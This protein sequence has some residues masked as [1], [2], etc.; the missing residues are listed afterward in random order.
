M[1]FYLLVIFLIL[2]FLASATHNRGGE[3]SYV[4]LTGNTYRFTI[5]TCTK[6]SAIADRPELE[7]TWGD[8]TGK[9]TVLRSSTVSMAPADAQKNY[10]II[11]HTFAG[12]GTFRVTMEDPNRNAGVIN[13][14]GATNS[15]QFPFCIATEIVISPFLGVNNS[16][17]FDDCPCPEL[18]CVNKR[19]CYNPQATDPDGDSLSYSLV[20]CLGLNCLAMSTPAVYQ[21]PS[22][23]GGTISID[24]LTG[25]M[26]W[27]N[28][29]RLGEYNIAVLVTEWRNG[30]KIGSVLRD[31]Q[32]TVTVCNNDPPLIRSIMDT[33]VVAG[34]SISIPVSA[35]DPNFGDRITLTATGAPLTG[36]SNPGS[37]T[38]VSGTSP[39]SSNF[40]WTTD[41]SNVRKAPFSLYFVAT[42][43]GLQ[44]NLSDYR[45]V[46]ITVKAPPPTGVVAT[47]LSGNVVVS[48]DQSNCSN[49]KGY[50]VYRKKGSSNSS[51]DCCG[52]NSPIDMGYTFIGQTNS[53]SDTS[54]VDIANLSVGEEYCYVVT[55]VYPIDYESCISD[56]ACVTLKRDVPIITHVT[57]LNTDLSSGVDSIIWA[58]ATDID[59][60]TDYPPPYLYKIFHQS[61]FTGA[62][63]LIYTSP[64]YPNLSVS[65]TVFVHSG[66]NSQTSP[67][68]Y[69][70][71]MYHFVGSD[72]LLIGQSN[73]ASSV[74]LTTIPNDNQIALNWTENVPWTNNSY[75]IYRGNSI[76]GTFVLIGATTAQSFVDSNLQN[77]KTY[78]YK[79]KS[80][81][82][83]TDPSIV[84]PLENF[85]QE[86]CDSPLDLT[87]PC[88]PVLAIDNS[89]E[90]ELNYLSWTNPNNTC[91]DDVT[92]YRVFYSPTSEGPFTEISV[93]NDPND[94][95]LTHD[96]MG[97]IAGCYYVTALDSVQY[98]NES[99]PSNV[100]CVD[101]CPIYFLPNVFTPNGDGI[102]DVFIPIL[103]YKFID[104]IEFVIYNRWGNEVFRTSDPMINWTGIDLET[105]KEVVDGVYFYACRVYSIRLSGLSETKLKGSISVYRNGSGR[106]N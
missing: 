49:A 26:C 87:P 103:P 25:T 28:P 37:F 64:F 9:D 106:A 90:D 67:N 11:D 55:I 27:L 5:T 22:S 101:N 89:C 59:T 38:S 95:T 36:V 91:A 98:N 84:S 48:W 68:N 41:C 16:V 7:I 85:S 50:K 57:V 74:F 43:N 31:I 61:G 56:E 1:R 40:S 47:P 81:G 29:A 13:I 60:V 99:E 105:G 73:S 97:S 2:G 15:D 63:N 42:D 65:D 86:V 93:I 83:Y 44:V 71:R 6:S 88:P 30:V 78:C 35:T 10:Y 39:I 66:I 3:I 54:F 24:P 104:S 4:H 96:D 17:V 20:P 52:Q 75:E 94:T 72:T 45:Q 58:K 21:Y 53:L 19:Y 62:N 18:A 79:V 51:P 77:G 76:G 33:C 32:I 23:F 82:Q 34:S 80:I 46:N 8:G 92:R 14:G 100:V 12:A 102:N 69:S 70:V